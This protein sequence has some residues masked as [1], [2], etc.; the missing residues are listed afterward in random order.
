MIPD[1]LAALNRVRW[2]NRPPCGMSCDVCQGIA[3]ET[4]LTRGTHEEMWLCAYCVKH[5]ARS[6]E[7]VRN[8]RAARRRNRAEQHASPLRNSV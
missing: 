7:V 6:G 4:A 1:A 8:P 3:V 2:P 5:L